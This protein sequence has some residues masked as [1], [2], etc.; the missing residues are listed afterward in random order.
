MFATAARGTV[1]TSVRRRTS[2]ATRI[3]GLA[4]LSL[5]VSCLAAGYDAPRDVEVAVRA[6]AFAPRQVAVAPGGTVTWHVGEEGHTIVADDGS[7]AFTGDGGRGLAVGEA[8]S[9]DVGAAQRLLRYHCSIHGGPGGQG[10][11]GTIVVGDPRPPASDATVVRV[12]GDA[13]TLADAVAVAPPG[14]TVLLAPG[15]HE[16]REEVVVDRT[17]VVVRGGGTRP[18]EVRLRPVLGPTGLADA[19]VVLRGP[20]AAIELLTVATGADAAVRLV[21]P[22]VA[23]RDVVLVGDGAAEAG[24]LVD[25]ARGAGLHRVAASGFRRGGIVVTPCATCGLLVDDPDLRDNLVGLLVEGAHGVVVRGGDVVGNAAGIVVRG[26]DQ[27]PGGLDLTGTRLVANDRRDRLPAADDP[28]RLLAVGAGI[29]LDRVADAVVRDATFADQPH[30][31]AVTGPSHGVRATG[32]HFRGQRLDL[33]WDGLGAGTCFERND[34]ATT[35]PPWLAQGHPCDGPPV[36][37]PWPPART[38]L[39]LTATGGDR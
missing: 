10:M 21:G 37:V 19:A 15:V 20:R 31:L 29:W 30:G 23:A 9:I 4:V 36:G 22:G 11:A 38:A 5:A 33:L 17:D 8:P 25:G 16:V 14:A 12:P 34:L 24:A 39:V 28:D 1:A 18:D 7:F 26:T 27:R 32:N 13:A 35:S 6:N 3:G 2:V